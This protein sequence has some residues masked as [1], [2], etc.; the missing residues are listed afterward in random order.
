MAVNT[1][2]PG[3]G[4]TLEPPG[5]NKPRARR[6]LLPLLL[7]AVIL[8]ALLSIYPFVWL[9]YMSFH[10]VGLAPGLRNAKR[11][12]YPQRAERVPLASRAWRHP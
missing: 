1:A 8:L 11:T 7:P 4:T 10:A 12:K 9:I 5:P 3:L 6:Y 2:T